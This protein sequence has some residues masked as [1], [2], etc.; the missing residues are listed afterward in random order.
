MKKG[1]HLCVINV[2][3]FLLQFQFVTITSEEFMKK[4]RKPAIFVKNSISTVS[5]D[6]LK[7]SM[8]E[9][10]FLVT[11]AVTRQL[12]RVVSRCILKLN[13]LE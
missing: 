12:R 3:K 7:Q 8:K 13:I 4:R 1:D 11:I 2:E 6:T 5:K 9:R 10:D